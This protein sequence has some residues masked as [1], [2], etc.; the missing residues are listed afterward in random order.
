MKL[1][2]LKRAPMWL[3]F[4]LSVVPGSR[5]M[6]KALGTYLPPGIYEESAIELLNEEYNL[7]VFNSNK[8]KWLY[9]LLNL[10][11]SYLSIELDLELNRS[12]TV[13]LVEVHIDPLQLEA[14]VSF[15]KT[16]SVQ[17]VLLADHLPKLRIRRNISNHKSYKNISSKAMQST[18]STIKCNFALLQVCLLT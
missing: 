18:A 3:P 17:T 9:H 2:G 7:N 8:Y 4:T 5:S 16:R 12:L 6:S 10:S 14:A 1:S 13:G 11:L 15:I